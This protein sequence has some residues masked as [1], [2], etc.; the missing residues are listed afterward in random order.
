MTSQPSATPIAIIGMAGIFPQAKNL[1]E[2]WENILNQIDCITDVPPSR[3]DIEEYYDANPQ[4]PDKTYSKRGGFLPEIDFNPMEFGLP[5]NI[6][7]STDT[8]QILSLI[9]AQNALKDAGYA[10]ASQSIRQRTGVV[11]GACLGQKLTHPLTKRLEYPVWEKVLKSNGISD[12]DTQKIIE[13]IK[14]A[15]LNWDENTFPGFL[16]N[17]IAGRIANRLDLGGMNCVVDAACAS[18][19]G[20]V[21]MAISELRERRSDM[22]ISG[23]V[24]TDNTVFAYMCFSKTPAL[25]R[26]D[27]IR[28]F[29]AQADGMLLGEG[30]GMV[31][32]KRLE[33][34]QR[35]C[36]RIY[37]VIKGLGSS[38]DGKYKSIYAPRSSGQALALKRAYEDAGFEPATVGLLEAHGTG[39]KAGD[40]AEIEGLKQVF[41]DNNPHKQ[42][43]ALGSIKSQIG[44][45]KAAAGAASLI[46]AALAL[47]HKIL[48]PTIN[49]TQPNPKLE[50]DQSPFY[51]NTQTRPWFQGINDA[52]RRAGIS[53]FGFG[54]A[55]YH[56]VLEEYQ[57][58][59]HQNYRLHPNP[60]TILLHAP[61]PQLLLTKCEQ[62]QAQ[63]SSA[64]VE[65]SFQ[66]IAHESVS[67]RIPLSAARLGF[68]A[69]SLTEA[70]RLLATA[71]TNLARLPN[72]AWE[73]PQG[74]YYRSAGVDVKGKVVALFSGQ[75]SQYVGMGQ[76]LTM[77]FPELRQ[78][79]SQMDNLLKKDGF[80]PI[81]SV[82]FPPTA[83][84]Q[85]QERAQSTAL[86]QTEKAQPAIGAMSVGLYKILQQGG[87]KPDFVAGHSFGELTALWAGRV[88][89]DDDYFL[90]TK[91]RGKAMSSSST[92]KCDLGKMLAVQGQIESIS[93][94]I[95]DFPQITIANWNSPQQ[96]VLAGNSEEIIQVKQFLEQRNYK[97]TL[98]PVSAAFHT[99]LVSHAQH[100]FAQAISRV[101]FHPPQIPVYSNTTTHPYPEN[102]KQ[103]E[104]HLLAQ[105]LNPV[106]FQEEIE[107]I[108]QAG[109]SIF[110]EFGPRSILTNLVKDIL[111]DKPHVALALNASRSKDSDRQ[112]REALVKLRVTGLRLNSCDR[113]TEESAAVSDRDRLKSVATPEK[114]KAGLTLK[115][116]GCN[117]GSEQIKN[118]FLAALKNN[119]KTPAVDSLS[120]AE[121]VK[122]EKPPQLL[123]QKFPQSQLTTKSQMNTRKDQ[124]SNNNRAKIMDVATDPADSSPL[125]TPISSSQ[126]NLFSSLENTLMNFQEH[127]AAVNKVQQQY[128]QNQGEYTRQF[129][130]LLREKY[131]INHPGSSITQESKINNALN[132]SDNTAQFLDRDKNSEVNG[133]VEYQVL[134][135]I[136]NAENES[137]SLRAN[138]AVDAS[139]K[140][141]TEKSVEKKKP[142]QSNFL[143]SETIDNSLEKTATI[144]L[145][146]QAVSQ[147]NSIAANI[148]AKEQKI[149]EKEIATDATSITPPPNINLELLTQSL[150]E[151]V[152]DKTG[153]PVE[154]L[155]LEMDIEADLGIDSIKRVQILGE[156]QESF[157]DLPEVNPEELMEL[158]T[159]EQIATYM[160]D[161]GRKEKAAT[162]EL[163]TL[164]ESLSVTAELSPSNG[165]VSPS[166]ETNLDGQDVRQSL[167]AII[168]AKTGYAP[169]VIEW[170]MDLE[171]DLGIDWGKKQEIFASITSLY[172]DIT[173]DSEILELKTAGQII[174]YLGSKKNFPISH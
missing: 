45:T 123:T 82:V 122:E 40:P 138:P 108:Y 169:E 66:K 25:S 13:Q 100:Q 151:I 17:V 27:T 20:A 146:P 140:N 143:P 164:H 5:P 34:A 38:S 29:D 65:S 87:F 115:I 18:S 174:E 103:V 173:A 96:I 105:M 88:L 79:Y 117:Y 110:V 21:R 130:Q 97:A 149:T 47:H 157:P 83:F 6:L 43:I 26:Q 136:T 126:Q 124:P 72:Q 165:A 77:N 70:R 102:V 145:Q 48:P 51:I 62:I 171:T 84:N 74:I 166:V 160:S 59:Q 54:G 15:Y 137:S 55:N 67:L 42:Y 167:L 114:K 52:P 11:L 69:E 10:A 109:G 132:L 56:A 24:D 3:W 63:W 53:S 148:G 2:Y 152:S 142:L 81:S 144:P 161:L 128:L 91:A 107:Q 119:K 141:N 12:T 127:Q 112:F 8:S 120:T 61:N 71:I 172:P 99:K 94:A 125:K 28:P 168:S 121:N 75:G 80:S 150:L 98:L 133:A 68:V 139:L 95:A 32:L 33:D 129:L 23:G 116:T 159:L 22:M 106:R 134:P 154:M 64:Q 76:T 19:L 31:V 93:Q 163:D 60:K 50:L 7:K 104:Q 135:D 1:G 16:S 158:R 153:Y 147:E 90:L 4:I 170:E 49:V 92:P 89:N 37:A 30:I 36:D 118:K 57:G 131:S 73:H 58:E 41:S 35:D 78:A 101:T 14:L 46:K 39:T 113:V 44:H 156:M 9:V 155:E 111:A 162:A 85:E 86:R